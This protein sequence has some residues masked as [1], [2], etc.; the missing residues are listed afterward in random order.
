MI[1]TVM[2]TY[3]NSTQSSF[4]T[5]RESPDTQ[6]QTTP[7]EMIGGDNEIPRESENLSS[8]ES[9]KVQRPINAAKKVSIEETRSEGIPVRHDEIKEILQEHDLIQ[10][11]Y[12]NDGSGRTQLETD[13]F[14]RLVNFQSQEAKK[15]LQDYIEEAIS[16]RRQAYND[17]DWTAYKKLVKQISDKLEAT[18]QEVRI[19]VYSI[20]RKT[21]AE[22]TSKHDLIAKS[23]RFE[24][25][26]LALLGQWQDPTDNLSE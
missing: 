10:V 3:K 20:L 18:Y 16:D 2:V 17:G 12:S 25:L 26:K 21:D 9:L 19:Q 1:K 6:K 4:E 11:V 22:Y 8:D 14:L 7:M 24:E 13:Y 23:D 5:L 15:Y